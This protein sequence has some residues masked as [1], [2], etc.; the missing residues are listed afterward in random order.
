M[1]TMGLIAV[2]WTWADVTRL[3]KIIDGLV[4][5]VCKGFCSV[6]LSEAI[7]VWRNIESRPMMEYSRGR[8]GIAAN[9]KQATRAFWH[10]VLSEWW[11]DIFAIAGII[12]WDVTSLSKG[13]TH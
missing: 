2:R 13:G 5:A 9:Q 7:P 6:P 11:R 4:E 1:I 3:S 10:T 8:I 12:F